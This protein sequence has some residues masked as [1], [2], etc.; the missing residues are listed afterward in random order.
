MQ[1]C[2]VL[3][4]A[5]RVVAAD[6]SM[7]TG[8]LAEQGH[9][10]HI[11]WNNWGLTKPDDVKEMDYLVHSP[12]WGL[13]FQKIAQERG[14]A[15]YVGIPRSSFREVCRHLGLSGKGIRSG[16]Q[17][18]E[19]G[20]GQQPRITMPDDITGKVLRPHPPRRGG[21]GSLLLGLIEQRPP[22]G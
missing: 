6:F 2:R 14:V 17:G 21:W 8:S 7:D 3:E 11:F 16:G 10:T 22:P 4:E 1:F 12:R 5:G 15:C 18:G 19:V 13:G 9:A 20:Q